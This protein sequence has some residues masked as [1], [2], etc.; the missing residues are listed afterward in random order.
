MITFACGDGQGRSEITVETS[1][2]SLVLGVDWSL[3]QLREKIENGRTDSIDSS[4]CELVLNTLE[5]QRLDAEATSLFVAEALLKNEFDYEMVAIS[6]NELT[7]WKDLITYIPQEYIKGLRLHFEGYVQGT[8]LTHTVVDQ[9]N[10][11]EELYRRALAA[12]DLELEENIR[13][14]ELIGKIQE[15]ENTDRASAI[16]PIQSVQRRIASGEAPVGAIAVEP[17]SALE[18][19]NSLRSRELLLA[20]GAAEMDINVLSATS[21]TM[22]IISE[23]CS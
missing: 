5:S 15:L 4:D 18:V 20:L 14:E 12:V 9:S 13:D 11:G 1:Q 16:Q 22:S 3:P 17:E 7:D 10:S 8:T 6:L 19:I 23:A 2:D 21:E